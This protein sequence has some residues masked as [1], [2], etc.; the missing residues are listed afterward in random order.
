MIETPLETIENKYKAISLL[1]AASLDLQELIN[2]DSDLKTVRKSL[3]YSNPD[4]IDK[5]RS[6]ELKQKQVD[7]GLIRITKIL[8]IEA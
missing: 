4:H 2:Y 6:I 7:K 3:S 1:I 5:L 8:N